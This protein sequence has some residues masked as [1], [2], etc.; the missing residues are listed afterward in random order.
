MY[1]IINATGQVVGKTEAPYYIKTA[2]NGSLAP[3]EEREAQGLTHLGRT[4]R[5]FGRVG[6]PDDLEL[7]VVAETDVGV[8]MS[9][10]ETT[11][12]ILFVSMA[13]A[14][15]ID[16]TTAGE[17]ASNFAEWAY[18][19]SYKAGAIR[20]YK[21]RLYRCVQAHTSQEDWTPVE[22]PSLWAEIA[23]P[24]EEWPQWAQPIGAHDAYNAGDK[25]SHSGKKWVSEI[26][27]NVWEPGVYG[28]TEQAEESNTDEGGGDSGDTVEEW[29][30]WVQPS[31]AHDAYNAGDK[32]SHNGARWT[33]DVS[34]NVWEPGVYGW[35]EAPAETTANAAAYAAAPATDLDAMTV[36]QLKAYAAEHEIDLTGKTLKADILAAIKAAEEVRA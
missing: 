25:V 33:S 27:A 22:T 7:V 13:E 16:S 29:P 32:V 36:A 12:S 19:V 21:D 6:L 14:G 15:Q 3:C 8:E 1:K 24:S 34:A 31:G 11:A 28:W 2:E 20:R 5:L 26:D 4:Y 35:T 9:A 30:E 10:A 17:H 23:D 18:P